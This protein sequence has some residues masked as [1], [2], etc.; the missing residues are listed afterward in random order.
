MALCL[1]G[2]AVLHSSPLFTAACRLL[3]HRT[4]GSLGMDTQAL[5][6][7]VADLRTLGL[8]A[9]PAP[10][11]PAG[12]RPSA[13]LLD[14]WARAAALAEPDVRQ[15]AIWAIREAAHASGVIP[16]SDP[17][18]LRGP[19]QGPVERPDGSGPQ[20]A[21]LDLSDVPGGLPC[22][23]QDGIVPVDLR[24]GL[25]GGGVRR[26]AAGGVHG[27]R[28]GRGDA[29]RA[30]GAGVPPGGPRPGQRGQLCQ[31]S[32]EGD[33][34]TVERHPRADRRQLLQHRRGRLDGGGSRAADAWSSSS[35]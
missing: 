25:G 5:A 30:P 32:G 16:A 20:P 14:R 12:A 15:A 4:G 24:A 2:A 28:L 1:T 19:G 23:A 17:G 31:G 34:A 9:G 21:R 22:G 13:E 26:T 8:S 10:R 35:G 27:W 7:I 11:L 29:R 33:G 3:A 6:E 18:T